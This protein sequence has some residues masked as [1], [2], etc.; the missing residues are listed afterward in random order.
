MQ[1]TKDK[2]T[3]LSSSEPRFDGFFVP[4]LPNE[5]DVRILTHGIFECFCKRCGIFTDTSM[6][7]NTLFVLMDKFHRIFNGDDVFLL[8]KVDLV[9]HSG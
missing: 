3:C 5:D 9:K 8:V 2:V 7:E 6:G 1:C 4:H